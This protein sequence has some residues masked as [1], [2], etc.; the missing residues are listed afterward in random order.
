MA[1][2][3]ILQRMR[4]APDVPPA[5]ALLPRLLAAQ[6]RRTRRRR[7]IIGG[8]ASAMALVLMVLVARPLLDESRQA[9]NVALQPQDTPADLQAD[10]RALDQ[11]LQT[12]YNRGASDSEV[13][14]MWETRRALVAKMRM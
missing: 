11:A 13:A 2:D 4:C 10:V 6:A 1:S 8:S 12:A 7:A 14:P 5:D 9:G 3:D